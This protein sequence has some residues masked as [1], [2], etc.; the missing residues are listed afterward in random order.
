MHN[1]FME[2]TRQ[3]QLVILI[4]YGVNW[5]VKKDPLVPED[6]YKKWSAFGTLHE[7]NIKKD[8]KIS[9]Y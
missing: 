5:L 4:T 2:E 7:T 6:C 3:N 9:N 1:V 8:K